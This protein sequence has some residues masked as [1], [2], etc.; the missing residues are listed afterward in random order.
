MVETKRF[1]TSFEHLDP[2]VPEAVAFYFSI[3]EASTFFSPS[4]SKFKLS[5][6]PL[7]P[8]ALNSTRL[9][10]RMLP[11]HL[12][13]DVQSESLTCSYLKGLILLWVLTLRMVS[14]RS[15][16]AIT[17][18]LAED[19]ARSHCRGSEAQRKRQRQKDQL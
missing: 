9:G 1:P 8:R 18:T 15:P 13:L 11:F 2:A 14:P 12:S 19:K 16:L 3:T 6:C 10:M 4:S 7:E 5:F 17:A